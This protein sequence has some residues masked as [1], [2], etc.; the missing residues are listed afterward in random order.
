VEVGAGRGH[1]VQL[2]GQLAIERGLLG[3]VI[4]VVD[5]HPQQAALLEDARVRGGR[6]LEVGAGVGQDR[7]AAGRGSG[8]QDLEAFDELLGT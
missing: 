6:P 5:L 3:R 7:G 1:E 2:R 4:E 8:V